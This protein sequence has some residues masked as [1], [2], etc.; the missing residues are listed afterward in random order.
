MSKFCKVLFCILMTAFILTLIGPFITTGLF[1]V[2]TEYCD[3]EIAL[4][5]TGVSLSVAT[6]LLP[7]LGLT[8]VNA[9]G[10]VVFWVG[11]IDGF[12]FVGY[13][14]VVHLTLSFILLLLPV[15]G[16]CLIKKAP[17]LFRVFV[18]IPMILAMVIKYS[19]CKP[20]LCIPDLIYLLLVAWLDIY[21]DRY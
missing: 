2:T 14:D 18:Y 6:F 13:D 12:T 11:V 4:G 20:L 3:F 1:V 8:F 7:M 5:I 17:K 10:C 21:V 19:I 16:M 9:F 15:V